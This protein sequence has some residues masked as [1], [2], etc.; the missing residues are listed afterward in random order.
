MEKYSGNPGISQIPVPPQPFHLGA[1]VAVDDIALVV[2]KTPGDHDQDVPLPDPDLLL[3]L[4]LDPSHPGDSVITFHPDVVRA[5]HQLGLGEHLAIALLRKPYPDD[6]PEL[7]L[8]VVG[9]PFGQCLIS[10]SR[11]A[12]TPLAASIKTFIPLP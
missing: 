11:P 6:L 10:S 4:S 3:D 12:P 9:P 1:G 5:H 2:L 8:L 7:V